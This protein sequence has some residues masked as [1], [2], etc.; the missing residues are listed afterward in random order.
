MI[1]DI[2]VKPLQT[3]MPTNGDDRNDSKIKKNNDEEVLIEKAERSLQS[4]TDNKRTFRR[5]RRRGRQKRKRTPADSRWR[6]AKFKELA[7][8]DYK[9]RKKFFDAYVFIKM[10]FMLC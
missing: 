8:K 3:K 7:V 10:C 9:K 4:T 5:T 6:G 2:S 1:D